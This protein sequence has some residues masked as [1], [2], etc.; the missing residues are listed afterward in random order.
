MTAA[1]SVELRFNPTDLRPLD[2]PTTGAFLGSPAD[3]LEAALAVAR[4]EMQDRMRNEIRGLAE[5][6]QAQL[7]RIADLAWQAAFWNFQKVSAPVMADAYVRAYRRANAGDVPM[8]VIYSLADRH[9]EKI[10]DYFHASS[11]DALSQGFATMVNRR[12][13]AKAAANKVMDAYGLSP[14]QMRAFTSAKQLDTPVDS[15]ISR[16]V[17]ARIRAYVDRSFTSRTK[18]LSAQE[19]HNIDEQ[20]KQYAWMW[21]QDKGKLS[22]KAQKMWVTARDERVCPVCGPLHGKKVGINDRFVTKEGAFWTPGLHPNCRC[23]IRLLENRF[24][25]ADW[26]PKEH[27]RGGDPEN[28]G[29][30]SAVSRTKE[31]EKPVIESTI[32]ESLKEAPPEEKLSMTETPAPAEGKLSM[33]GGEKL[34]MGRLSMLGTLSMGESS[35]LSMTEDKKISAAEG[36]KISMSRAEAMEKI[37]MLTTPQMQMQMDQ[38]FMSLIEA[39]EPYVKPQRRALRSIYRPTMHIQDDEGREYPVYAAVKASDLNWGDGKVELNHHVSFTPSL[40]RVK[41]R[42]NELFAEETLGEKDRVMSTNTTIAAT[43]DQNGVRWVGELNEDQVLEVV[44]WAAYQGRV[45][46][47]DSALDRQ[48]DYDLVDPGGN[49]R[50]TSMPMS[51]A[52]RLLGI[53]PQDFDIRIMRMDEGH[54]SRDG[55]TA[56]LE[57]GTKHG[58]EDWVT[59]GRYH[60][61]PIRSEAVGH[62][63]SLQ[64][65]WIDPDVKE[66]EVPFL[67]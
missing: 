40:E 44:H 24:S 58:Y 61:N 31:P 41:T 22:T 52:A 32:W 25:K 3:A 7:L 30:F 51:T 12:L 66:T 33:G 11:R 65:Y 15:P 53:K 38:A 50:E 62:N 17:K 6:S 14:R 37:S 60:A 43:T 48:L 9:A 16:S 8:S 35:K 2:L 19:E 55:S 42:A 67:G 47:P 39:T 28:R 18:K 4:A 20:A 46:D 64:V 5:P 1:P 10:G 57:A 59:S 45:A 63:L 29:R 54:D 21:L 23:V 36:E 34:S 13:P 26:D 56:M 27:P 49:I